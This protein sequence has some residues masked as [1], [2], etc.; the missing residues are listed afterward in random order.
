SKERATGD[1]QTDL[2]LSL[3]GD[4][5][6]TEEAFVKL[7]TRFVYQ[8][9]RR[10]REEGKELLDEK[11]GN[12]FGIDLG[13]VKNFKNMGIGGALQYTFWQAT[14]VNKEVIIGESDLFNLFLQLSLGN[15]SPEKHGKIDLTLDFPLTGKNAS[16]TYRLG[17]S[18]KTIFR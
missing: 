16:A 15:L 17:I 13:F 10:Y 12:S 2:N 14:K 8:F 18:L 9:K 1:G 4:I 7:G 5:L 11:L 6:L 3:N